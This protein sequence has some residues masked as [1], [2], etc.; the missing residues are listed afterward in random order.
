MQKGEIFKILRGEPIPVKSYL[1]ALCAKKSNK[2]DYHPA[3]TL[4]AKLTVASEAAFTRKFGEQASFVS[5][6]PCLLVCLYNLETDW[7]S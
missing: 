7:L 5:M 2:A 3:N 4:F 1:V 6:R